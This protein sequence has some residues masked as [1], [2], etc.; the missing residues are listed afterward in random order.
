M[1]NRRRSKWTHSFIHINRSTVTSNCFAF[2]IAYY[3]FVILSSLLVTATKHKSF[4]ASLI[5]LHKTFHD[6]DISFWFVAF[7]CINRWTCRRGKAGMWLWNGTEYAALRKTSQQCFCTKC[8]NTP[9]HCEFLT[10]SHLFKILPL[11]VL[12]VIFIKTPVWPKLVLPV[13]ITKAGANCDKATLYVI[14][15]LCAF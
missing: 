12:L 2:D 3:I 15:L 5:V 10:L 11:I 4:S 8:E 9:Q 13:Q 1:R 7:V 6:T 14:T